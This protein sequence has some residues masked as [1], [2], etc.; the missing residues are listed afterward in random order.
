MSI[1]SAPGSRP[2]VTFAAVGDI[3]LGD[4]PACIGFGVRSRAAGAGYHSLFDGIR[5]TLASYELV[6]GNL[7][8]VLASRDAVLSATAAGLIDRAEPEAAAAIS[9]AG[10]GLVGLANNHI[11]EYGEE[12]LNETVLHLQEN[13]IDW[14][15]K[16]NNHIRNIAGQQIAFLSWSLLPDHYWP[17]LDPSEHYN[18]AQNSTPILEE[19][20]RVRSISDYVVLMLHWG[21][22]L[23][24]RPSKKQQEMAHVLVDGGVD[25]ILGHHAHVLQPIERY[26]DAVIAYSLGNFVMDSWLPET[27]E[28]VILEVSLGKRIGYRAI[29]VHIDSRYR[30]APVV[31]EEHRVK[32]LSALGWREPLDDAIYRRTLHHRRRRYRL[33]SM[34]HFARNAHRAGPGNI[35]WI[36]GWGLRRIAFLLRVASQER[37]DPDIVYRG[38]MH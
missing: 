37:N 15:G 2:D 22:E 36:L 4:Q 29:P 5:R 9:A 31:D 17:G 34:L 35:R 7:E 11:F 10:I 1:E 38:P 13:G 30:P 24:D 3:F 18:I 33:S 32:T 12:G 28:S 19:V 27:R 8:S 6:V 14:T 20:K 26:K 25:V 16:K 23:I 21:N